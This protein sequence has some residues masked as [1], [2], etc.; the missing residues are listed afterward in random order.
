MFDF[1]VSELDERLM[2]GLTILLKTS[3]DYAPKVIAAG[4][5]RVKL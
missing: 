3:P 4:E 2:W 1:E 5:V